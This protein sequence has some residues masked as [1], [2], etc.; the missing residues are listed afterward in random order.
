M[1]VVAHCRQRGY[2]DGV[3]KREE[4]R[5]KLTEGS[6]R[7][8]PATCSYKIVCAPTV[9]AVAI[10]SA[11]M[12]PGTIVLRDNIAIESDLIN[13]RKAWDV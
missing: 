5:K 1:L 10:P 7:G 12:R 13:R 9:V 6:P 8:H 4:R 3:H 2:K 11:A